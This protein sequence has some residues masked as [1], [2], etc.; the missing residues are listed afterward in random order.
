MTN[1]QKLWGLVGFIA[2]CFLTAGLGAMLTSMSIQG[3]Y[4]TI[5]KPTF[6]PPNIVFPIVWNVLYLLLAFSAWTLWKK[7][8]GQTLSLSMGLFIL[9]L[10]LNVGWSG[11]FFGMMRIDWALIEIMIM[12]VLAWFTL[13]LFYKQ[14]RLAGMLMAP[15]VVWLSFAAFLNY[16]IWQLN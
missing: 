5:Q 15:Y 11:L 3:W 13:S 4:V 7:K 16:S 9:Q 1:N 2:A 6:N 8:D 10:L 14:S 12:A